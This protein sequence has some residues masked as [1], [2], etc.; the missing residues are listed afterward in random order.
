MGVH[1]SLCAKVGV[2]AK[3]VFTPVFCHTFVHPTGQSF[4]EHLFYMNNILVSKVKAAS[5]NLFVC[6]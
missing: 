1:I 2:V 4:G 5:E 3:V 6:E